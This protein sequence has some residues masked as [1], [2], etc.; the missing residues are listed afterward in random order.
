MNMQDIA[1]V[2]EYSTGFNK[3]SLSKSPLVHVILEVHS[4]YLL[5]AILEKASSFRDILRF[6][7]E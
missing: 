1:I 6:D 2:H 3:L 7:S 4:N 5:T